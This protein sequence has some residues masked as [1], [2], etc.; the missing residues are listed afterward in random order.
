MATADG[1]DLQPQLIDKLRFGPY[2]LVQGRRIIP[3]AREGDD[4]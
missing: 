4:E 3:A 1:S 2:R